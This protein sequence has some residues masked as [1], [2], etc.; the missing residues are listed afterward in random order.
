MAQVR[1]VPRGVCTCC[2]RAGR[3][4]YRIVHVLLCSGRAAG[5]EANGSLGRLRFEPLL[6]NYFSPVFPVTGAGVRSCVSLP[7]TRRPRCRRTPPSVGEGLCATIRLPLPGTPL[8]GQG[9]GGTG[10]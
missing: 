2:V 7:W 3:T 10:V 4:F 8:G 5:R 9:G 1:E 6:W